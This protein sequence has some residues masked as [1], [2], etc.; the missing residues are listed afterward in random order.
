M[1]EFQTGLIRHP[2]FVIDGATYAQG[3]LQRR[4]DRAVADLLRL[5]RDRLGRQPDGCMIRVFPTQFTDELKRFSEEDYHVRRCIDVLFKDGLNPTDM[6]LEGLVRQFSD[7][8][9]S[10]ENDQDFEV[11]LREIDALRDDF[12]ATLV[13]HLERFIEEGTLNIIRYGF[14]PLGFKT[15][16]GGKRTVPYVP[17]EFVVVRL[18]PGGEYLCK[19]IDGD[20]DQ[21]PFQLFFLNRLT[22]EE[23]PVSDL[24]SLLPLYKKLKRV[25][26]VHDRSL[27]HASR[28]YIV[29]SHIQDNKENDDLFED[30]RREKQKAKLR[31]RMLREQVNSGTSTAMRYVDMSAAASGSTG[32]GMLGRAEELCGNGFIAS[33][34]RRTHQEMTDKLYHLKTRHHQEK[35]KLTKKVRVL[36]DLLQ[37]YLAGQTSGSAELPTRYQLPEGSSH[38]GSHLNVRPNALSYESL[39]RLYHVQVETCILSK[40]ANGKASK[41]DTR[42]GVTRSL[43]AEVDNSETR[44][45]CPKSVILQRFFVHVVMADWLKDQKIPMAPSDPV[46]KSW[47][48]GNFPLMD[49]FLRKGSMKL[50][51]MCITGYRA[52]D[53]SM[54]YRQIDPY[55]TGQ[56]I[57]VPQ[58]V[59]PIAASGVVPDITAE[60]DSDLYDDD[61]DSDDSR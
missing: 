3:A 37:S 4:R 18:Q 25:R 34:M 29:T 43:V 60:E 5:H 15:I 41:A 31:E 24:T 59:V 40:Q 22:H 27:I 19:G 58:P 46:K 38:V 42:Q 13:P 53:I 11:E 6:F 48:L 2:P 47:T 20:A 32:V 56:A 33:A 28:P 45:I 52:T 10:D 1:T 39:E 17:S 16:E 8:S 57:V 14:T 7:H 51:L 49:R 9:K 54:N 36:E 21:G 44:T 35:E 12:E 30:E 26:E 50:W 55:R 61:Y 23:R